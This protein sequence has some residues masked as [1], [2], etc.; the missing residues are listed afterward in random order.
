MTETYSDKDHEKKKEASGKG[1]NPHYLHTS[2][3]ASIIIDSICV[4]CT[5]Q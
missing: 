2:K 5:R 1:R 3:Y 4:L